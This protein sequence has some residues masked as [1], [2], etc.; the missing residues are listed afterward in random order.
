M[1]RA[2]PSLKF[3]AL[4]LLACGLFGC[5]S[6]ELKERCSKTNWFEYSRDVANSGRY[7]EEDSFL[8]QCKDVDRASATQIDLGFKSG[9]ARYCTYE[10]FLRQGEAGEPVNFKMCDG[11]VMYQMQERY[12]AGLKLFCTAE[13]GYRY[14]A[15]GKKYKD[16]CLKPAE[17]AFLPTYYKGRREFLEKTIQRSSQDLATTQDLQARLSRQIETISYE[18]NIL[19]SPQECSNEQVYDPDSKKTESRLICQESSY[20]RSRRSS[21]Y[22]QIDPLRREYAM[23]AALT[24]RLLAD[25]TSAREELTKI[26]TEVKKP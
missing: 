16:V 20:I 9:R 7:L 24:T 11:L 3:I 8:K 19:P 21:L 6:W 4:A 25:L 22:V 26:P 10:N 13:V 15:S 18:I 12:A 5:T 1:D 14:G 23:Q 2:V 17:A